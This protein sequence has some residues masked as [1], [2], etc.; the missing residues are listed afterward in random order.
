MGT[1]QPEAPTTE[2]KEAQ[3]KLTREQRRYR[4]RLEHDARSM[5]HT[6]TDKFTDYI[7]LCDEPESE[8]TRQYINQL[9]AQW[10]LFCRRKNLSPQV[11]NV[12]VDHCNN[13]IAEYKALKENKTES[14][15]VVSRVETNHTE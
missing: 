1:P 9:N 2:Q 15:L 8:E 7:V 6:L 11:H 4:E 14:S 5:H 3:P 12:I 13:T 10:R